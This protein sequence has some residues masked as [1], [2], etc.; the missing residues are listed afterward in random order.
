[1][2][3]IAGRPVSPESLSNGLP[4]GPIANKIIAIMANS[5]A[6]YYFSSESELEFEVRMRLAIID[7]AKALFQSRAQFADFYTS[8]CNPAY[9]DLTENGGF[10]L[11][12]GVPASVA[13]NDIFVN[14]E[15]YAF[16]C[17]TAMIMILYRATLQVLPEQNF[18]RLFANMFLWGWKYDKDLAIVHRIPEDYLPGDIRYFKNPDV[19]PMTP[20]WQGENGVDMGDGTYFGHGIGI[21][22]PEGIIESLKQRMKPG[23]TRMPYLM[24]PA[25]RPGFKYL[26]RFSYAN[27]EAESGTEIRVFN[28]EF[29]EQK[30]SLDEY[31][32]QMDDYATRYITVRF[33]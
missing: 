30:V 4:G 9:W 24:A 22:T 5:R 26:Y 13:I 10:R 17:A 12:P 1:M 6:V 8:R 15:M 32:Q 20:Q 29:V 28:E 18:N 16:E 2:I 3:N 7:S 31:F 33:G 11:K 14:G 21:K 19:N 27:R 25:T 23:A